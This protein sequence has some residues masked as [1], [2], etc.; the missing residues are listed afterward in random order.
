MKYDGLACQQLAEYLALADQR[1]KL[2]AKN[3]LL[4]GRLWALEFQ[5]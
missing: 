5:Q 4:L 1:Q 3:P 2:A